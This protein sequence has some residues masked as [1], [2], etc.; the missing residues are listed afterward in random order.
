MSGA[1]NNQ[2]GP[3][4]GLIS[5]VAGVGGA[6]GGRGPE[7]HPEPPQPLPGRFIG[8]LAARIIARLA[9]RRQ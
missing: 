1:A 6:G 4:S 9:D 8:E 3:R 5:R 7:T 2:D